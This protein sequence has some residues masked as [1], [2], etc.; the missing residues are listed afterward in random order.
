MAFEIV[1]NLD[2]PLKRRIGQTLCF[3]IHVSCIS[4]QISPFPTEFPCCS[5]FPHPP[6]WTTHL[7]LWV[8]AS[9]NLARH[10]EVMKKLMLGILDLPQHSS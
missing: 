5:Q 1:F 10:T 4:T 6:F 7:S 8:F 9:V 2:E 3:V